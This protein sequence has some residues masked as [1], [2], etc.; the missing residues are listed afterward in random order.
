MCSFYH[1]NSWTKK[2]NRP[3]PAHESCHNLTSRNTR[4]LRRSL[5]T[6]EKSHT[7]KIQD[8]L[9]K[10]NAKRDAETTLAY[11]NG[12]G[13]KVRIWRSNGQ[14]DHGYFYQNMN[15]KMVQQKL[16]TEPK[17]NTEKAFRSAVAYEE[18]V[19]ESI[20]SNIWN[21]RNPTRTNHKYQSKPMHQMRFEN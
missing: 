15:I 6:A 16:C 19:K 12:H 20:R 13:G 14:P 4:N 3:L 2:P 7:G 5:S 17:E 8:F 11:I 18:G 10:T 21:K 9:E 1:W